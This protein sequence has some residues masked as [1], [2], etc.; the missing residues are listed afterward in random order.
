M[1]VKFKFFLL[2]LQ[3]SNIALIAVPCILYFK[4]NIL[5][6][7]AAIIINIIIIIIMG[8]AYYLSADPVCLKSVGYN[9]KDLH[10]RHVCNCLTCKHY[11]TRSL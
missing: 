6:A 7:A 3:Y 4:S 9:L 11:F 10:R 8:K 1:H 5:F 2:F